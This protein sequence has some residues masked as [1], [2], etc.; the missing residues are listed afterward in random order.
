MSTFQ[1]AL[2]NVLLTL[3]YIAPGYAACKLKKASADHLPTLSAVL[4][5]ICSPCLIVTSFLNM[6]FPGTSWAKW[7][8]FSW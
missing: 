5:Y 8:C 2:S 3:L 4:I 1:I 7:A 6:D